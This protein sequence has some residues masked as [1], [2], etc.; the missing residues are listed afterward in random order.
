MIYRFKMAVKLQTFASRYFDSSKNLEITFQKELFNEIILKLGD[1]KHNKYIYITEIKLG[2]FYS[3]RSLGAKQLFPDPQNSKIVRK[4]RNFNGNQ[5][6]LRKRNFLQVFC[7]HFCCMSSL[8]P[9]F[10]FISVRNYILMETNQNSEGE[11]PNLTIFN[12]KCPCG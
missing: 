9:Y 7:H 11:L 4:S 8:N 6:I 10:F 12:Q 3:C 1:Y 2:N 5:P